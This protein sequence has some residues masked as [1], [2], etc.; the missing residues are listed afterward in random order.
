MAELVTLPPRSTASPCDHVL[1]YMNLVVRAAMQKKA[2][3]IFA[4]IQ[5]KLLT[6]HLDDECFNR[7]KQRLS[8]L[9]CR[10]NRTIPNHWTN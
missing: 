1:S 9:T 10:R 5:E 8:W 3:E 4:K 2:W 7:L 6:G